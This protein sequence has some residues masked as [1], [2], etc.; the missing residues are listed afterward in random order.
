MLDRRVLA[1]TPPVEGTVSLR[2]ARAFASCE[3]KS[4]WESLR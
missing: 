1:E 2:I 3:K 4:V